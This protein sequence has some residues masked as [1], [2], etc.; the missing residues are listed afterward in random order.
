M[1]TE[2]QRIAVIRR[3]F[4]MRRRVWAYITEHPRASLAEISRAL[5][6][7]KPNGAIVSAL[8][9]LRAAGYIAFCDGEARAR[10]IRI[11]LVIAKKE[12]R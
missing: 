10:T 12:R 8:S 4:Q 11:P 1:I 6:Y 9:A 3:S 2:R 7:D 5:G